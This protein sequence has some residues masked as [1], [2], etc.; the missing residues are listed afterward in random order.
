MDLTEQKII[1]LIDIHRDEIIAFAQDMERHPEPGFEEKRTSRCAAE[2]L[3]ALGY[4][5]ETGLARTGVRADWTGKKGPNVT[6][7]AEMDAIGCKTHP[8]ADASNGTAHACGHHAQMAAMIGAALAFADEE[9]R[10]ALAGSVSFFA[11]PAEEYIDAE[12]RACLKKEGIVFAGSGKSELIRTGAFDKTDIVMTTH[13]HMV[14]VKEDIYLGNPAC[15]GFTAEKVTVRG[16]AAHAA[17]DPWNGVNALSITTS[18]I[19]MMGLMRETFREED[20]ARLHNVIRKAGDVVNSVPDEAVI[21]TKVRAS[22]LERIQ[23]IQNMADRAYDGAAYAFGG[24]IEREV[25]QGYMPVLWREADPVL[26]EA[27]EELAEAEDAGKSSS[28]T[29]PVMKEAM[30]D[31]ADAEQK[32]REKLSGK[33]GANSF[34][35]QQEVKPGRTLTWREVTKYDFNNACTD[36]GDLTHLFPVLNFTFSGFEGKLHGADFR[37]TDYDKAYI[38]PAKLLALTTY[39]L[40]KNNAAEAQK[41]LDGFHPKFNK[42]EYIDYIQQHYYDHNGT[43][44]NRSME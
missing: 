40:L 37:I 18:A 9:V 15:N 21:E 42:E 39:K 12:K 7:I 36:V 41:I 30:K 38:L 6:I 5:T 8:L 24:R 22:S 11:V 44:A 23:E 29:D 20:H 1:D 35:E 14:P 31:L 13:V 16:K 4:H 2:F 26:V 28:E 32:R 25:L 3:R 10:E 27:M 17:I 34:G 19:Q 43:C 33:T